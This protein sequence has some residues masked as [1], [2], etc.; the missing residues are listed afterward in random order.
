MVASTSEIT[1]NRVWP[2]T[3]VNRL[4]QTSLDLENE[5]FKRA[6]SRGSSVAEPIDLLL[7]ITHQTHGAEGAILRDVIR[8]I[9]DQLAKTSPVEYI[10][11]R[12]QPG[13]NGTALLGHE[14]SASK[15]VEKI[16]QAAE[17]LR[18]ERGHEKIESIDFLTALISVSENNPVIKT[19]GVDRVKINTAVDGYLKNRSTEKK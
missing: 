12:I 18:E 19:L 8:E 14:I 5:M 16:F 3:D 4:T 9:N 6:I 17:W 11:K 2:N 13:T 15:D 7:S 10:K 1:V